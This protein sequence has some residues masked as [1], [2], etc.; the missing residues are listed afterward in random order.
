MTTDRIVVVGIAWTLVLIALLLVREW[1]RAADRPSWRPVARYIDL[2]AVVLL[3]AAGLAAVLRL[4][5][6]AN[7][8]TTGS[9]DGGSDPVASLVS[10]RPTPTLPS[11]QRSPEPP[12][13]RPRSP[14]PT[15]TPM[16]TPAPSPT[17]SPTAPPTPVRTTVPTPTAPPTPRPSVDVVQASVTAGPRF[18]AYDVVDGRVTG[19]RTVEVAARFTATASDPLTYGFP[20]L[21]DPEGTI[22]L[23]RILTGPLAGVFLNPDGPG[24]DYRPGG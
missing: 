10:E 17:V 9:T 12:P 13:S 18:R 22:R 24:V 7:P 21:S 19:Y 16:A 2:L 8:P 14:S 4:A 20:T 11:P 5:S 3:S 6:L 1:V 23:V 15:P